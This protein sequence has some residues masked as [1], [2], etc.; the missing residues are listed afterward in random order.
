MDWV[1][2]LECKA[3]ELE[4]HHEVA[5][6][7]R[8]DIVVDMTRIGEIARGVGLVLEDPPRRPGGSAAQRTGP[9]SHVQSP[10]VSPHR[11]ARS[12]ER[13]VGKEGVSTGSSRW[14]AYH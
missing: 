2:R 6:V 7:E 4:H 11:S 8:N 14:S 5:P 10:G 12:E 9:A 3:F 1:G 13:R